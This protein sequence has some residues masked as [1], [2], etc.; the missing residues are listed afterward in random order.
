MRCCIPTLTIYS[1][2]STGMIWV[3]LN[4]ASAANRQGISRCLDSGHPVYNNSAW[5]PHGP[6]Q[7]QLW[8][9]LLGHVTRKIVSKM[10]YNV[11]SGTINFTILTYT[12]AQLSYY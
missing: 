11:S 7:A 12:R 6:I 3:T 2:T 9:C 10:T 1:N 5:D 4:M 8:H